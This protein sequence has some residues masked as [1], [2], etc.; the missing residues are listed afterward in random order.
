MLK[1]FQCFSGRSYAQA[2][3]NTS[4][5]ADMRL[6]HPTGIVPEQQLFHA[7]KVQVRE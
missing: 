1:M 7:R 5:S 2:L 3:S 6:G 4:M